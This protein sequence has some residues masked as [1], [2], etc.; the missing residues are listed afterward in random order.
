M[1]Q[2][3]DFGPRTAAPVPSAALSRSSYL[4]KGDEFRALEKRSRLIL[5]PAFMLQHAMQG[6]VMNTKFWEGATAKRQAALGEQ[7]LI[8]WHYAATSDKQ[9]NRGGIGGGEGALCQ[10]VVNNAEGAVVH[11]EPSFKCKGR[12]IVPKDEG[13]F[14]YDTHLIEPDG[15]VSAG[16]AE[17]TPEAS[18]PVEWWRIDAGEA[19]TPRWILARDCEED[20][21]DEGTDI[22]MME[23]NAQERLEREK[24]QRK[25]LRERE[26]WQREREDL[27]KRWVKVHDGESNRAYWIDADS[28]EVMWSKP[29]GDFVPDE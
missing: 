8:A 10:A 12:D 13:V 1:F 19:N 21:Y 9:R 6:K 2:R 20:Q 5:F 16:A 26:R 24:A 15:R 27:R 11:A 22:A 4:R 14:V 3:G 28:A 25:K 29:P 23:S 17:L 7:D 18:A